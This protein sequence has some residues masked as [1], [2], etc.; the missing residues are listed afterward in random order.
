[1]DLILFIYKDFILFLMEQFF[2]ITEKLY[3]LHS[4]KEKI[5]NLV[6]HS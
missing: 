6:I 1:M 2:L 4:Y 5:F 3:K